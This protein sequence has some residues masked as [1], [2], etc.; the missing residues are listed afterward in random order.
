MGLCCMMLYFCLRGCQSWQEFF[1]KTFNTVLLSKKKQRL[2]NLK[3]CFCLSFWSKLFLFRFD[4]GTV[5]FDVAWLAWLS[6]AMGKQNCASKANG[7]IDLNRLTC[8]STPFFINYKQHF[9]KICNNIEKI[10]I[11]ISLSIYNS[12]F[13]LFSCKCTCRQIVLK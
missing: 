6:L 12:V 13:G 8:N 10:K 1:Y 7:P 5:C 11:I 2:I 4:I 9:Q 3:F